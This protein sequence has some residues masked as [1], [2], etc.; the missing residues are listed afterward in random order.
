MNALLQYLIDR[1]DGNIIS[2]AYNVSNPSEKAK[3]NLAEVESLFDKYFSNVNVEEIKQN[4]ANFYITD[5]E[6]VSV[7]KLFKSL[8]E[9]LPI[10]QSEKSQIYGNILRKLGTIKEQKEKDKPKQSKNI[11]KKQDVDKDDKSDTSQSKV[12]EVQAVNNKSTVENKQHPQKASETKKVTKVK[13]NRSAKKVEKKKDKA[14]TITKVKKEEPAKEVESKE[15]ETVKQVTQNVETTEESKKKEMEIIALRRE[16]EALR[17]DN[18]RKIQAILAQRDEEHE[19][20]TKENKELWEKQ[21]KEL[22]EKQKAEY[23]KKDQELLEQIKKLQEQ[24]QPAQ[25]SAP[26]EDKAPEEPNNNPSNEVIETSKNKDN[27]K[28]GIEQQDSKVSL[29]SKKDPIAAEIEKEKNKANKDYYKLGRLN[30][31]RLILLSRFPPSE[32]TVKGYKQYGMSRDNDQEEEEGEEEVRVKGQKK[33]GVVLPD[34]DIRKVKES[35]YYSDNI[36]KKSEKK[37]K[38]LLPALGIGGGVVALLLIIMLTRISKGKQPT[39]QVQQSQ[40]TQQQNIQTATQ[41]VQAQSAQSQQPVQTESPVDLSTYGQQ[42]FNSIKKHRE[43]D[44]NGNPILTAAE[45]AAQRGGL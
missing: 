8:L 7:Q 26:S 40:P 21:T 11:E 44:D 4:I 45:I 37:N 19:K 41:P 17:Q 15:I 36:D 24:S 22:L 3:Q 29:D 6:E 39:Q 10:D 16:L 35:D 12:K 42:L 27:S 38:W 1:K 13:R 43:Y 5:T 14:K 31:Q 25:E 32:K 23:D 34:D 33:K 28:E 18:E 20:E 30:V 9:K 2:N